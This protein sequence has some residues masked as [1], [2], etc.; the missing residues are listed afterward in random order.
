M[1]DSKSNNKHISVNQYLPHNFLAEKM[2]LSSLLV[3]P[4]AIE[5]TNQ[6]ISEDVFYFKN[7]QELYRTISSMT[8]NNLAID[9]FTV[10]TFLQETG[11]LEKIGGVKVLIDLLNQIPNLDYL[12]EY[13][14][15][16]KDKYIRRSLIKLGYKTINSSYIT[17]IP[18]EEIVNDLETNVFRLTMQDN[19]Q[20]LSS[21]A[22]LIDQIFFELK[23]KALT[24]SSVG[25]KSGF[26]ALDSI[27]EG[28]HKSDLIILAGRPS[29]G[30]TALSLS[31]ALN[32]IKISKLPVVF[33]SLEMAKNQIMY[34]LLSMETGINQLKLKSGK[35]TKNE[36]I[37]LNQAFK[38]ISKFPL[39]INDKENLLIQDIRA[40]LKSIIF[41]QQKIG[42]VVI[43]YIQLIQ[44]SQLK[45]ETR[46]QELSYIT[47][48]LKK[49][50]REF[51][52][53][54]VGLSQLSR[55]VETR[56]NKKP[57]LSDLRESGSI[58]QDADLILMLYEDEV[59]QNKI[60]SKLNQRQ[61]NLIIAKHRN[62]PTGT[63]DLA[64]NKV[65]VKFFNEIK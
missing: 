37:K 27:T 16:L 47:R 43:D 13:L 60:Q 2:V 65:R 56:L 8:K 34:R 36:W 28:F 15:L 48:S 22:E 41:E 19:L 45:T 6:M 57:V 5:V 54:I 18:L 62:G 23:T 32:V 30:K 26:Y 40:T 10:L 31:I 21:S 51:N 14:V 46:T 7:H 24:R 44:S 58:E 52:I 11:T 49:L 25:L 61:L 35:L 9:V 42:L 59:K 12:E 4:K 63:I 50:A 33:F 53:P 20:N 29:T 64:F 39:F 1:S 55:N 3:N 38:L 17:N